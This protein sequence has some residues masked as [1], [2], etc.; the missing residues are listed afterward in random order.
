MQQN[1]MRVIR[2]KRRL[3]AT[4]KKSNEYKEYLA[5]KQVEKE[6]RKLVR[7]AKNKFEKKLAKEAK[8]ET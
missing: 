2:K 7:Q 4:Y 5:Y 6:T 8:K 1:V 3:W